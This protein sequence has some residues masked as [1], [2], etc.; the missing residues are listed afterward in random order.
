MECRLKRNVT[1]IGMSLQIEYHLNWNTKY[2]E[3]GVIPKTSNSASIGQI[4]ILFVF[5]PSLCE[6]AAHW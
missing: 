2:I 1:Q 5:D 6:T 4:S 3:K